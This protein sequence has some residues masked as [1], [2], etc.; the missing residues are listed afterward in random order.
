M[1]HKLNEV[2]EL[3]QKAVRYLPNPPRNSIEKEIGLIKELIMHSRAPRI[4]IIGRRGAGKSSL[5]NAIFQEEVAAVGSVVSETP[6]GKWYTYQNEA[7]AIEIMDTRGLGDFTT[8]EGSQHKTSQEQLIS[9]LKEKFPDVILFLSKAKEVD[10][11]IAEDIRGLND[12]LAEIKKNHNYEAP[13]I[14][15]VTQV[16]ELDPVFVDKPPFENELKQKNIA[17]AVLRFSEVFEQEKIKFL[18]VI[19]V[20]AYASYENKA[21]V[22]SRYW[23]IDILVEFLV[24]SMPREAKIEL[25]RLAKVQDVQKKI[26]RIIITSSATITAGIA[27]VP[28]PIADIIPITSTQVAMI[29]G[30][31]YLT[32][33]SLDKKMAVEFL[34][35]LGATTGAAIAFREIA[36]GM[37][38]F[39]FPGGGSVISSSIAFGGTWAIG[40]AAI[41]YFI[42]GK[43]IEDVKNVFKSVKKLKEDA[44]DKNS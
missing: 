25:A 29:M 28:I 23:N 18:K 11:R 16:D 21:L 24:D 3:I 7:G 26:A 37:I 27:A 32:N 40:E 17:T 22:Y 8:P 14:G 33:R 39:V 1:S 5:I 6:F 2:V 44:F 30:I 35:A 34:S 42:E 10:S 12:V 13:V 38:K 15:V 4:M 43:S 41:A 31:A 36:R 19:P 20:V 9:E